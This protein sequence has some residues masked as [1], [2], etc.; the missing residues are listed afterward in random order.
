MS[1]V[2]NTVL[3]SVAEFERDLI[4]ERTRLGM[5][6]AR[7]AGKLVGRPAVERPDHADVVRLRA[8]GKSW[9]EVSEALGCSTWAARSAA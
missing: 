1:M 4:R 7:E 6:K 2:A 8:Q 5:A 9:R 3:A